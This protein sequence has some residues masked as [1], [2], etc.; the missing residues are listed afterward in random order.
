MKF[1][2]ILLIILGI[3]IVSAD[4]TF[5]DNPDDLLIIGSSVT[6]NSG[7]T[8]I[9]GRITEG[10]G[11]CIYKWNCTEWSECFSTGRQIRNCINFGTCPNNYKVPQTKQNCHYIS[12]QTEEKSEETTGKETTDK[13]KI[14][15]YLILTVISIFII[16]NLL[17]L[18]LPKKFQKEK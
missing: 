13:N 1:R 12:P 4:T 8:E 9:T 11:G 18:L 10:G 14:F 16:F 5:F 2:I 17:K 3:S 7:T 6:A 15:I